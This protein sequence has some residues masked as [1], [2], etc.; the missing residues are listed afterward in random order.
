MKHSD[1]ILQLRLFA[2]HLIKGTFS[3]KITMNTFAK[4]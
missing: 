4:L 3:D 2:L 1:F